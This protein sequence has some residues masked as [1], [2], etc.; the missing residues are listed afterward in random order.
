M[1]NK[2]QGAESFLDKVGI[3]PEEF[4]TRLA[5]SEVHPKTS[6]PPAGDFRR[7]FEF[8][9]SHYG[10]VVSV[11]ATGRA[12][13]TRQA[14][15]SAA[16]RIEQRDR[17]TV[18]DSANAA[19]GEGLV[20]MHAAECAAAGL[21]AE[22]VIASVRACIKRTYTFASLKTLDAGVRGGRVPAWART[23]ANLLGV[24]PY[25][26]ST[27]DGRIAIGGFLLGRADL[28]LKLARL[29]MRR[30]QPELRYRLIVSHANA[31]AEG[32]R[33]LEHLRGNC[34]NILES[35]LV[36]LGPAVGVHG[37]AGML[38]VGFQEHVPPPAAAAAL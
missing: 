30:M 32:E 17:V 36:P 1:C 11:N 6:Q 9:T 12:S 20:A 2:R 14:A 13:G 22:A 8:L 18:I 15:E 7:M 38:V 4:Y 21:G 26:R 33:L 10:H 29:V 27:P 24:S 34:P 25:L 16:G 3:T 35:W 19:A 28:T 31:P 23:I 37:G 5:T